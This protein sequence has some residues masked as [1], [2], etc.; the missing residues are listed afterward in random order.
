MNHKNN[1]F[2]VSFKQRLFR[3]SIGTAFDSTTLHHPIE[4][5]LIM[6]SRVESPSGD[7]LTLLLLLP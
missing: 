2:F 3:V 1:S 4:L 7:R 5:P 6:I